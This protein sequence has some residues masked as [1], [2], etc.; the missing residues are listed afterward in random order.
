[1]KKYRNLLYYILS[2]GAFSILLLWTLKKGKALE[3]NIFS[4]SFMPA[5]QAQ[6][7]SMGELLQNVVSNFHHPLAILILQI[8]TILLVA[9]IFGLAFI[10][11][12]QPIVIGEIVAG[13][14]LGPSILGAIFPSF[15]SF[16]FPIE[17]L[18]NIHF[19]SQIGLILFM[20][21][22]GLDLDISSIRNKMSDALAIS[23]ASIIVPFALGLILAYFIYPQY[24][25]ANI[26]FYAFALFICIIMSITAF[27]VLAR[28][29]QEKGWTKTH[30]GS[31]AITSA[32][33]N[34]IIAWCLLAIV[35]AL[36]KAGGIYSAIG[37]ISIAILYVGFMILILKPWLSKMRET[38]PTKETMSKG[39]IASYFLVLLSSAYIAELIGIHALFGAFLAGII[40]PS[41]KHFRK[42]LIE[43]IEDISVVLL[44]PLFFV[45]TGL[46][47]DLGLLN[48][49][50]LWVTFGWVILAAIIGKFIGTAL[51][52]RFFKQ[53]WRDSLLLGALMNT[54]GLMQL[55]VLDIGY[56]LGVLT[57]EIFMIMILMAIVTTFMTGPSLSLINYF[58]PSEELLGTN[59]HN[60]DG[61]KI[62]IS[63]GP[64]AT[65]VK[66]LRLASGMSAHNLQLTRVTT[67]HFT[68]GTDL[69]PLRAEEYANESFKPIL[70]EAFRT[71]I[72]VEPRYKVTDNI[73]QSILRTAEEGNYNLLLIGAGRPVLKIP[74]VSWIFH[75]RDHLNRKNS[76]TN[77]AGKVSIAGKNIFIHEKARYILEHAKCNIGVFIDREFENCQH[78]FFP[79]L[80]REDMALIY[81]LKFFLINNGTTAFIYDKSGFINADPWMKSE[82]ESFR[83]QHHSRL[84]YVKREDVDS[85]VFFDEIQLLFISLKGWKSLIKN[86]KNWIARMP[87]AL[88][89]KLVNNQNN[90]K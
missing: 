18:Q 69:H 25:P 8:V 38:H 48:K 30:L 40:M 83:D 58:F 52:A 65:G 41:D 33:A 84:H 45:Y 76:L 54:R 67:L 64:S 27:P 35:I 5:S 53:T 68:R 51:S 17:S 88:I 2:I 11:I 87:S 4:K 6:A 34:D 63:Y 7:G 15:S 49:G 29:I 46:R 55:I 26:P 42:I 60:E 79:I 36:V 14:F 12:G 28:I 77:E 13:I 89:M 50:N 82:I 75:L 22:I 56:E 37:T 71:G 80:N 39:I 24:T 3:I 62:L 61:N 72:Q 23:H 81:Y 10:A 16:L 20:F 57:P 31:I 9:R 44:L 1:M 32:A 43:K 85:E 47:T 19:L 70:K 21:V 74:F 78:I 59:L 90:I 86:H 66:L 73:D